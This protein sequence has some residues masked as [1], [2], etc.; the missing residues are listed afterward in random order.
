MCDSRT[1]FHKNPELLIDPSWAYWSCQTEFK[2][3][4]Y[5]IFTLHNKTF[6]SGGLMGQSGERLVS[7]NYRLNKG[8]TIVATGRT[9]RW[10]SRRDRHYTSAGPLGGPYASGFRLLYTEALCSWW[11]ISH[12]KTNSDPTIPYLTKV[13]Y[14]HCFNSSEFGPITQGCFSI[15]ITYEGTRNLL[16]ACPLF[17]PEN[18][19]IVPMDLVHP[20]HPVCYFLEQTDR[21][22]V[23]DKLMAQSSSSLTAWRW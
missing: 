15:C 23:R 22:T 7:D 4:R 19:A 6:K 5:W 11:P 3:R 8:F 12:L 13:S 16:Q 18:P 17:S 21:Q 1:Q 10:G 9:E 2:L 14:I 20:I